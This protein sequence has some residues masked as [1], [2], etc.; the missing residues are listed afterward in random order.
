MKISEIE[1]DG[2]FFSFLAHTLEVFSFLVEFYSESLNMFLS[3]QSLTQIIKDF[4]LYFLLVL[5]YHNHVN[6]CFYF[7]INFE[8]KAMFELCLKKCM[9]VYVYSVLDRTLLHCESVNPQHSVR[10]HLFIIQRE[11]Q[12]RLQ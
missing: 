1:E 7:F 3:S 4:N 8:I 10:C 5:Q 9:P 2:F 12:Q 6:Q 11:D